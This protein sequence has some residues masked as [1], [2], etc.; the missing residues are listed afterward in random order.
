MKAISIHQPWASLI[1]LGEKKFETRTWKPTHQGE[2]LIHASRTFSETER[3][4]LQQEPFKTVFA[5]HGVKYST[6]LPTGV[7]IALATIDKVL[8]AEEIIHDLSDQERS[9]G[10]YRQGRYAWLLK[11]ITRLNNPPPLPGRQ[12]IFDIPDQLVLPCLPAR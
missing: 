10:D 7:P 11:N 9:F 5:K 12:A 2:I 1:A 4:L 8:L 6:D 3:L